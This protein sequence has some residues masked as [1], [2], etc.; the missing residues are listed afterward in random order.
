MKEVA[1]LQQYL[2]AYVI[3]AIGAME[4]T[5]YVSELLVQM[6]RHFEVHTITLHHIGALKSQQ[7]RRD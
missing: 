6:N 4:Y 5:R 7:K 3:D 1:Y 2:S